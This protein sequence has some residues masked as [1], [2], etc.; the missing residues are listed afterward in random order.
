MNSSWEYKTL[1]SPRVLCRSGVAQDNIVKVYLST[2]RPAL[3]YAVS[4]MADSY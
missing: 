3:E 2:E 4:C 1:Y